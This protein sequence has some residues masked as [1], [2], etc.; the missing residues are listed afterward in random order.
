MK[1]PKRTP[2]VTATESP[3]PPASPEDRQGEPQIPQ[4]LGRFMGV[5]PH[6]GLP[7]YLEIT[8]Q[9]QRAKPSTAKDT[10]QAT[11]GAG[12]ACAQ[13][14]RP[15]RG[16]VGAWRASHATLWFWE[17]Q[18]L[19]PFAQWFRLSPAGALLN[20]LNL[21]NLLKTASVMEPQIPQILGRFM[22][23]LPHAGRVIGSLEAWRL[24]S[25]MALSP[26]A[27]QGR[28]Q[29]ANQRGASALR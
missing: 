27:P 1:R 3:E 10:K 4:I 18:R 14:A 8:V 6:A 7:V 16:P 21:L 5:L 22:G 15:A 20:L 28:F 2:A 11:Q 26:V 25:L 13:G 19:T 17:I 23:V 12:R 9:A 29:S 24:R